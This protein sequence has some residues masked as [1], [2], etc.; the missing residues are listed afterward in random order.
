MRLFTCCAVAD[1][2]GLCHN[3]DM[4]ETKIVLVSDNH[5]ERKPLKWLRETYKDY[6]LFIH[7]GDS[8]M[9]VGDMAG[10]ICV[11]GNNDFLYGSQVPEN[12]VLKAGN[13]K[14]YVCH[15]HMDFLSYFH[16]G[17]MVKRA[18][19]KGCDIVFFGHVHQVYDEVLD[20]VRL[21]NPGSIRYNRDMSQASYMLVHIDGDA[22]NVQAMTYGEP[23]KQTWLDRL[24]EALMKI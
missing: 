19:E 1:S 5:G 10:Y 3:A 16:Y 15:G 8:E 9:S 14:I 7:C 6:D 22:V 4:S 12:M 13:H 21:L 18:K 24:I 20:G 17:P 23:R 11:T 2:R